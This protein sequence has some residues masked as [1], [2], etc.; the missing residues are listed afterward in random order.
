LIPTYSKAADDIRS[1]FRELQF[2]R[3]TEGG[4]KMLIAQVDAN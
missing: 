2:L 1:Y 4:A 3:E